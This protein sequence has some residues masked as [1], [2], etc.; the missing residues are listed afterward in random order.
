MNKK[1]FSLP[2]FPFPFLFF[3]SSFPLSPTFS[4]SAAFAMTASLLELIEVDAYE[5][6]WKNAQDLLINW[7]CCSGNT[8]RHTAHCFCDL[9]HGKGL[10]AFALS[11]VLSKG[12]LTGIREGLCEEF[13]SKSGQ[14]DLSEEFSTNKLWWLLGSGPLSQR[15]AIAKVQGGLD[16]I[17]TITA[18]NYN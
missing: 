8:I 2:Y 15:S 13:I 12:I 16:W 4:L 18:S 3:L 7:K 1:S 14:L 6:R 17:Q 10:L 5:A 9:H 11:T